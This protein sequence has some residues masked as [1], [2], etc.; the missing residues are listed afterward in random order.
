[1][2]SCGS[3][4]RVPFS[5]HHVNDGKVAAI[6][7]IYARLPRLACQGLCDDSC[8]PIGLTEVEAQRIEA[9]LHRLPVLSADLRCS[10]LVNGRCQAYPL[11]PLICRL[12]GL[13]EHMLCPHGCRPDRLLTREEANALL[14]E[15]SAISPL[16]QASIEMLALLAA[17]DG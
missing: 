15:V 9:T 8:G 12:Y 2:T 1:M 17:L 3:L 5:P 14:A 7:S 11:R 13:A 10:L 6:E 16:T 4:V